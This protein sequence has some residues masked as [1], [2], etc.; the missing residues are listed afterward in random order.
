[1]SADG[2]AA[3]RQWRLTVTED[4]VAGTLHVGLS[5]RQFPCRADHW[6]GHKH[7]RVGADTLPLESIDDYEK[8]LAFLVDSTMKDGLL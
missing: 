4:R 3:P 1:M 8:L 6:D 5:Y 7:T 2:T